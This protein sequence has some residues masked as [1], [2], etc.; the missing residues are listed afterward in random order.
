MNLMAEGVAPLGLVTGIVQADGF[1]MNP[2]RFLHH[3]FTHAGASLKPSGTHLPITE[4]RDLFLKIHDWTEILK[5]EEKIM[6]YI[7]I[8]NMVHE[9]GSSISLERFKFVLNH[10]EYLKGHGL[11]QFK[12]DQSHGAYDEFPEASQLTSE[13]FIKTAHKLLEFISSLH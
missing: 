9:H 2:L 6:V 1:L 7:L 5:P 8:F 13:L 4:R 10:P 11:E 12:Y 3:D